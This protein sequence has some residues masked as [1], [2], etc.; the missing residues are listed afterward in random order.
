MVSPQLKVEFIELYNFNSWY[1]RKATP[2]MAPKKASGKFVSKIYHKVTISLSMNL[3][4]TLLWTNMRV[5]VTISN[6]TLIGYFI[7]RI[8]PEFFIK[9]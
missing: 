7:G 3:M 2:T 6:C 9:D 1:P 8:S 5:F 4:W